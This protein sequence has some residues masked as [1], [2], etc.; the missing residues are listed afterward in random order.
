VVIRAMAAA[1]TMRLPFAASS[2]SVARQRLRGWLVENGVGREAVEDARVVISEMV[3][4]CVRHAS[5]LPDGTIVVSWSME[6]DGVEI[7]V[8]DG[9]GA[10]RPRNV[11]A[12]VSALAGRGMAIV[13]ALTHRWWVDSAPSRSTT[14][15]L[16]RM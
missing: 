3:A 14:H 1:V 12:P 5:P 4:N 13:D 6:P 7:A 16:L 11:Q 15:A 8:T 9:G 2:V 10:T